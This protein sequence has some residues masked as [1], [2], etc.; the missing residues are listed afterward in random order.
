MPRLGQ[1]A[2]DRPGPV[3]ALLLGASEAGDD[4]DR[5]REATEDKP[6]GGKSLFET[7]GTG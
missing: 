5:D 1:V 2:P 6:T 3:V 4:H 7:W